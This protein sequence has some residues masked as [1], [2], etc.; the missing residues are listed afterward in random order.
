[1]R[2]V[3]VAWT[4]DQM[5]AIISALLRAGVTATS[6]VVLAGGIYYLALHGAEHLDY[7]AF[8]GQPAA[9]RTIPGIVAFALSS[10][11]RGIIELGLVML[12]MTPVARV[13]ISVVGFARQRDYLYVGATLLVLAILLHNLLVGT[14]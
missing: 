9:L 14:L 1:M 3:R 12:V 5:Q 11:S 10:H 4:D 2:R 6:F 13:L 8:H 7:R